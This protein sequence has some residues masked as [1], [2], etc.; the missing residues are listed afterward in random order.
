MARVRPTPQKCPAGVLDLRA[1]RD[2]TDGTP[3]RCPALVL[4]IAYISY[5]AIDVQAVDKSNSTL[6]LTLIPILILMALLGIGWENIRLRGLLIANNT[7][8][9]I[10]P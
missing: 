4:D 7:G 3:K 9:K 6:T 2:Q 10:K 5:R 8:Q 1:M